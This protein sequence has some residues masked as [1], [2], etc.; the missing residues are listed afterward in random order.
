MTYD[1][2]DPNDPLRHKFLLRKSH[3]GEYVMPINEKI[4]NGLGIEAAAFTKVQEAQRDG[5]H[6][7][8]VPTKIRHLLRMMG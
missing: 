8:R 1:P 5:V 7:E 6:M 2:N 4:A 3:E